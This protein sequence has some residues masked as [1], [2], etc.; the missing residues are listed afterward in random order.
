MK[1]LLV[2]KYLYRKGGAETYFIKLGEYLKSLGNEVEYFGMEHEGRCVGNSVNAYTSD[3]DFHGGS[4]LANLT[5][6]IKTIYSKEARKKIRL[7][8]DDFKPDVVHLNNFNYQLTP[9][10]IY[11]IKKHNI[12]IVYTAHDVQLVCP[13]HKLKN[14][15]TDGLCRKC[16]GGKY[17]ECVKNNCVHSSK[18][19]SILGAVEAWYYKLRHTY[20]MIDLTV[21]PSEFMEKEISRNDDINGRTVTMYNFI[22]EIKPLGAECENYVLYFGRYSEEKGISNLVK[23]AKKLSN[24]PFVFAGKGE[25]ENEVNSADNIKNI[26]F[27]TGDE[28]RNIIEKALFT[29]L[30]AEWSENCPFSVMESQSLMTPVLGAKI[31]GIPELIDDGKT[32]ILFESGNLKELTEKIEYLYNN[33]ELCRQMSEN[34]RDIKY[35]T[36]KEYSEKLIKLYKEVIK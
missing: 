21:C 9:S 29:V 10:I 20:K 31:G 16:D 8:L 30:P 3:M 11:E 17:F 23:A 18:I 14:D 33:K 4:K 34:C 32:G 25:L 24:I 22:D 2:N 36:I 26:G 6:P 19:R 35:D 13:N 27:K 5:Y 1:I 15:Y 28:L 7:V 12:P